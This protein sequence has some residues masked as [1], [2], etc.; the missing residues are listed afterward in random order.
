MKMS[1]L[2]YKWL[3]IA[4]DVV[5]NVVFA[6]F[7]SSALQ[8]KAT[9]IA[10][11][12]S[13]ARKCARARA[14]FVLVVCIRMHSNS[15]THTHTPSPRLQH[16]SSEYQSPE[17]IL[18]NWNATRCGQIGNAS[19]KENWRIKMKNK[20]TV[21]T[22]TGMRCDETSKSIRKCSEIG[23]EL[24]RERERASGKWPNQLILFVCRIYRCS[25]RLRC[26]VFVW[27]W[28]F[29]CFFVFIYLC[30]VCSYMCMALVDYFIKWE[31]SR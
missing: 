19:R 11:P 7:R 2:P 26:I 29:F 13:R 21:N 23:G 18:V 10:L 6:F 30:L 4:I 3:S 14:M 9:G 16:C 8:S 1:T 20:W 28:T 25:C 15:S 5:N 31:R 24:E 12:S 27:W 17:S 22:A